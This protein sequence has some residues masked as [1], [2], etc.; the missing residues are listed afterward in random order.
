M[1]IGWLWQANMSRPSS[2]STGHENKNLNMLTYASRNRD[3]NLRKTSLM[4]TMNMFCISSRKDKK[5]RYEQRF[6]LTIDISYCKTSAHRWQKIF[7]NVDVAETA[8]WPLGAC[9]QKDMKHDGIQHWKLRMNSSHLSFAAR[10]TA[11]T[12]YLKQ[13]HVEFLCDTFILYDHKLKPWQ[14][15][16][17]ILAIH[18]STHTWPGYL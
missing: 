14:M 15:S 2:S 4:S 18:Y 5:Q 17:F 12:N 8:Q 3:M 7:R 10:N 11:N 16:T 9:C 6:K 1:Q 13:Q